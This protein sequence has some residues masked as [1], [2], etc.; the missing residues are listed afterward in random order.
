LYLTPVVP[1]TLLQTSEISSMAHTNRKRTTSKALAAVSV[2][3]GL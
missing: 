1:S 3:P 2:P